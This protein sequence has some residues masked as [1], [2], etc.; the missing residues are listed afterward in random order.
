M[1][2]PPFNPIRNSRV[3]TIKWLAAYLKVNRHTMSRMINK[4]GVDLYD[5]ASVLNFVHVTKTERILRKL[6][7][8]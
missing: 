6:D 4:N 7:L 5:L 1:S 8:K 2:H 3:C